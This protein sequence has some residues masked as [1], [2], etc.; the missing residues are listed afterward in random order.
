MTEILSKDFVCCDFSQL[1]LS[2][3]LLRPFLSCSMSSNNDPAFL[4]LH[5]DC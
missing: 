3:S 1:L 5:E 2:V 4:M